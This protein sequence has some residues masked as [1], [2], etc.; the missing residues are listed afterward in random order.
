MGLCVQK[1]ADLQ[2]LSL[3]KDNLLTRLASHGLSFE[4]AKLKAIWQNP[5]VTSVCSLMPSVAI[6]RANASAAMDE[7]LLDSEVTRL[8]ADHAG[9]TGKYFCRRCGVCETV[10]PDNIPIF[11]IMEMLMYARGY[12]AKDMAVR[13]FAKIPQETRSKM[14]DSDYSNVES[15]CPQAIP[16]GQMIREAY[17]ELK[18]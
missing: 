12:G 15:V 13:S 2:R 14:M 11:D 18:D 3:P 10:A 5:H 16:I 8:L 9:S 6:M 4:Q 7:R 17:L 1:E